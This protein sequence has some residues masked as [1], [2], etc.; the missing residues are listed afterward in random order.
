[1]WILILAVIPLEWI[2]V[3]RFD[4]QTIFMN[5]VG[6]GWANPL[7][8]SGHLWY[9]TMLMILYLCFITLSYIRLDK[10]KSSWWVLTFGVLMVVYFFAQDIL[11]TFSKTGPFLFIYFGALMFARGKVITDWARTHKILVIV[12]AV[13]LV[14]ISQY[15]YLLGWHDSHKAMAVTS[16]IVAGFLTFLC[17]YACLNTTKEINW[18]KWLSGISYEVYLVHMPII[19]LIG[20]FTDNLWTIVAV[21][22][23]LSL[24]LAL[25]LKKISDDIIIL[26]KV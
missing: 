22:L 8:I 4:L 3:G 19:P 15:V 12:A 26:W 1:M 2:I 17:L 23:V 14:T 25:G 7:G 20:L 24:I 13:I 21:D 11:T 6:L 16:F 18:V 5:V 9:I 10:V